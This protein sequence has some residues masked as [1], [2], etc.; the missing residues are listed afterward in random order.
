M[1]TLAGWVLTGLLLSLASASAWAGDTRAD[2]IIA[3]AKA[4]A[5]GPAWDRLQGWHER[6][7]I[8]R[9][10]V[11]IDY[12]AWRGLDRPA[13]LDQVSADGE[14]RT[15]GY[16]GRS[17][18]SIDSSGS[19][20]ADTSAAA[21]AEAERNAYFSMYGY[22]FRD[23]FAAE[24]RWIGARAVKS[25]AYDVIEVK[26]QGAGPMDLWVDRRTHLVTAVVDADPAHPTISMLGEFHLVEGVL[27]PFVV[28]QS[29]G[30]GP[31]SVRH[32]R[33]YDFAHVDP[34]RF[35]PPSP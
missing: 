32:I 19:V 28:M 4:A 20:T 7:A 15:Q 27:L 23:R 14:W 29:A 11:T 34:K 30:A 8:E 5:G 12:E 33:S 6:G 1:R 31:A 3:R 10:G 2:A 26:P 35:A 22:F 21:L 16:D 25:G 18:W 17:T 24:W 13:A 9:G